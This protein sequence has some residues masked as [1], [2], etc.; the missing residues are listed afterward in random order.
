MIIEWNH[1][2]FSSDVHN[3]PF[4]PDA[5]YVPAAAALLKDPLA[6]YLHGMRERGIDRAVVVH[7][8]PYGGRPPADP[9][10]PPPGAEAPQGDV[11]LLPARSGGAARDGAARPAGAAD[12]GDPLPRSPRQGDLPAEL[13]G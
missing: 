13:R 2:L 5:A 4:H 12:R 3:Y 8:E 10:L 7:P 11:P 6:E 9:G 1:H